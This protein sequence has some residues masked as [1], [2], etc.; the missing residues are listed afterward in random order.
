MLS[1]ESRVGRIRS[2]IP[3]VQLR[4]LLSVPAKVLYIEYDDNRLCL[5][6]TSNG[7]LGLTTSHL[8][9]VVDVFNVFE[10]LTAV[11][12]GYGTPSTTK[13]A[14]DP[15]IVLQVMKRRSLF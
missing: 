13:L 14:K 9:V 12:Y 7:K 1:V 4:S 15:F 2:A 11:A 3:S 10:R 8:F 5:V 6:T